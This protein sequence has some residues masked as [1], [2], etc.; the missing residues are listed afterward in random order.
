MKRAGNILLLIR[1]LTEKQHIYTTFFN[2]SHCN[3]AWWL[4]L[5]LSLV[6][7]QGQKNAKYVFNRFRYHY[8]LTQRCTNIKD[9][10][11]CVRQHL[12]KNNS[13]TSIWWLWYNWRCGK[14]QLW[15]CYLGYTPNIQKTVVIINSISYKKKS[16]FMTF[17]LRCDHQIWCMN[18]RLPVSIKMLMKD[19]LYLQVLYTRVTD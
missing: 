7:N 11:V 3:Y 13:F 19:M 15:T 10:S 1:H 9:G 16:V 18:D 17:L 4:A 2:L 14:K 12:I 8:C 5:W 6:W